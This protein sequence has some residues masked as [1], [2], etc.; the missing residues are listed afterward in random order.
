[1]R[2][3]PLPHEL[4]ALAR[5]LMLCPA[6]TRARA[7]LRVLAETEAA[8]RRMIQTGRPHPRHGDGSLI[9][10]L[11]I[12]PLPPETYADT[13]EILSAL[14]IAAAALLKHTVRSQI[15][16][17]TGARD[18]FVPFGSAAGE[19]HGRDKTARHDGRSGLDP[20]L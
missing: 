17:R 19:D 20:Y 12:Q 13:P 11:M 15:S 2:I 18:A 14:Q 7:A 9:A 4:T 16:A 6:P 1:M 5:H 8:A 10:R 3:R